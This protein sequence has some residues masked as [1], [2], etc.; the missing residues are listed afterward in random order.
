MKKTERQLRVDIMNL[1][2]KL[3]LADRFCEIHELKKQLKIKIKELQEYEN[4][5]KSN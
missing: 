2:G 4:Q 5:S 1:N 3:H